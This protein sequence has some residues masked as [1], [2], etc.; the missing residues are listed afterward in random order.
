M[1]DEHAR[2]MFA[3]HARLLRRAANG[4]YDDANR[5]D[6]LPWMLAELADALSHTRSALSRMNDAIR[7]IDGLPTLTRNALEQ[8]AKNLEDG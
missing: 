7:V 2:E 3:K 8:A 1:T 5:E 4:L 6:L